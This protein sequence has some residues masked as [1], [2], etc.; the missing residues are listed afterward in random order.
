[1]RVLIVDDS[2]LFRRFV[3]SIL[4]QRQDVQVVGEASDGLE[5]VQKVQELSPDLI[6]LD[7]GLPKLNGI[8]AAR[9]IREIAPQ[10]KILFVSAMGD[11][12]LAAEALQTSGSGYVVKA[13]AGCE[14]LSA[15]DAVL[16]G[17][18]FVSSGLT[19]DDLVAPHRPQKLQPT[20]TMQLRFTRMTHP[21]FVVSVVLSKPL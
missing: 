8:E 1:M 14:L 3:H 4:G 13:L 9:Q 18:V 21:F 7:V 15:V 11:S 12:Q 20:V 10:S 5:A 6:L 2:L 19:I 16:R 17:E